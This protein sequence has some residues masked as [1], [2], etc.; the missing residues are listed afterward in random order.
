MAFNTKA[1]EDN[2]GATKSFQ[3]LTASTLEA[4]ASHQND[5]LADVIALKAAFDAQATVYAQDSAGKDRDIADITRRLDEEKHAEE[6]Q[7]EGLKARLDGTTQKLQDVKSTAVSAQRLAIR[8]G[9]LTDGSR[10][11]SATSSPT[12]GRRTTSATTI[13]TA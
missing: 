1:I 11:T 12:D 8:K 9:V 2:K 10:T 13:F 3:T 4:V 5:T 6:A 7:F